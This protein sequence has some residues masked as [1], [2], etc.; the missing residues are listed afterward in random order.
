L[1]RC[2]Y[3]AFIPI[4]LAP[5]LFQPPPPCLP[6]LC[7]SPFHHRPLDVALQAA[8]AAKMEADLRAL[9]EAA[10]AATAAEACVAA[11]EEE[12]QREDEIKKAARVADR[13]HQE[14]H[15]AARKKTQ[16]L[17]ERLLREVFREYVELHG[18]L[19]AMREAVAE[20]RR[21]TE[22]VCKEV[23]SRA[24]L[25]QERKEANQ[26][27]TRALHASASPFKLH[28]SERPTNM[29]KI[30]AEIEA[31]ITRQLTFQP[32]KATPLPPPPVAQVSEQARGQRLLY[33]FFEGVR[34]P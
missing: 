13:E 30:R 9:R 1:C 20:Q 23:D 25:L 32:P 31:D 28:T 14:R 3:L 11:L 34:R 26:A 18:N 7:S 16:G 5:P 8:V 15:E 4:L 29:E 6:L 2:K 22:A 24:P 12:G 10:A 17:C 27:R 21:R 19:P 33:L